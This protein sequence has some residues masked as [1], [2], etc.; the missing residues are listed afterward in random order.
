MK[1]II[2]GC[3]KIG[4]TI[5]ESLVAEGHDILIIDNDDSIIQ[6]ITNVFDV[7]GVCGNCVDSDVLEEASVKTA[8]LFLAVTDSDELNML[9][10]FLAK[11]MGAQ[12]TIARIRT[13]EYNDKSLLVMKNN[14]EI[15]MPINPERLAAREL[16]NILKFPSAVKLETFSHRNMEMAEVVLREDSPLD[17]VK[18]SEIRGKF[19][20]N[21]LVCCVQRGEEIFIPDGSFALRGGDRIGMTASHTELQKLF[22]Y[23]GLLKKQARDVIILGGSRVSYYLAEMLA[24]IGA[25]VKIIDRDEKVCEL[26]G[27]KLPKAVVIRGDGTQQELLLREGLSRT[28]AFVALTGLDETNVLISMFATR[29]GVPKVIA[30]VNREEL[31]PMAEDLGLDCIV[32]PRKTVS[33]VVVSYARAIENSLGSNVETLYK[34]MD[35]KVEALEFNVREKSRVVDVPLKNLKLRKNILIIGVIRDRKLI[36]PTGETEI[37]LGDRVVVITANQGLGDLS[38]IL[39]R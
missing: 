16:F 10:C 37:Q 32:S 17:G 9:S 28:D 5:V 26:L 11:K 4:T 1:I 27:D 25:S 14:L 12:H 31:I 35:D 33:D 24:E 23:T 3:G 19:K 13:S 6:E 34:L 36:T 29:R 7:M 2:A 21:V 39:E 20:A 18:L 8:E 38:D 30:K 22:R 15:S